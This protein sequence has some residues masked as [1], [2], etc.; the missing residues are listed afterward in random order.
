MRA[1]LLIPVIVICIKTG[2]YHA[3]SIIS[4]HRSV[5]LNKYKSATSKSGVGAVM[6]LFYNCRNMLFDSMHIL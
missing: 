5:L 3:F 2:R 1:L 4:K 6:V